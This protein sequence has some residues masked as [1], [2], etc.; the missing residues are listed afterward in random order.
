[1]EFMTTPQKP[2]VRRCRWCELNTAL[3][4]PRFWVDGEWTVI[5]SPT[6]YFGDEAVYTD[7]I[8]EPCSMIQMLEIQGIKYRNYVAMK[9]QEANEP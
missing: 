1:M 6:R 2:V 9:A 4:L 7:A 5:L 3:K 8:C